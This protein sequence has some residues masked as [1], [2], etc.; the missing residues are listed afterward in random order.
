MKRQHPA[1]NQLYV[2]DN[3]RVVARSLLQDV[4][5]VFSAHGAL[6]E[7]RGPRFTCH[8][9]DG[10]SLDHAAYVEVQTLSADARDGLLSCSSAPTL[11]ELAHNLDWAHRPSELAEL[12]LLLAGRC[13]TN[14]GA[15]IGDMASWRLSNERQAELGERNAGGVSEA[16]NREIE[17]Q[18]AAVTQAFEAAREEVLQAA[19]FGF[20]KP[21]KVNR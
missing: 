19:C 15:L 16:L 4:W 9:Y 12:R 13:R 7:H 21:L 11:D 6:P 3:F 18:L 10:P 17:A 20:R 2:S 8:I 1:L 14:D 5:Y